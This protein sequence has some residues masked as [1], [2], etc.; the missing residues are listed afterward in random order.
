MRRRVVV[1]IQCGGGDLTR[2]RSA[3]SYQ[4]EATGHA[5]DRSD[6]EDQFRHRQY[7]IATHLRL[8]CLNESCLPIGKR[9]LEQLTNGGLRKA[10]LP[11]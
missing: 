4:H 3:A 6:E 1:L 7:P 9:W 2:R 5:G 10:G 11:E 8:N